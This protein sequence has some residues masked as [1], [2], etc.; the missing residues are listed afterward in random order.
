MSSS[1]RRRWPFDPREWFAGPPDDA[2]G[3]AADLIRRGRHAQALQALDAALL[4]A[5]DPAGVAAV[6]NK[7][8]VALVALGDRDAALE[9]F[10]AALEAHETAVPALVSIGNLL[11][12]AGHAADAVD[13]YR[14]ALRLDDAYAVAHANLAAAL[15]SLGD[16][17][18]AVR[19]L[20]A[21]VRLEGPRGLGRA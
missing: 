21:A 15:R 18:G 12:E 16:R 10:C 3:R 1:R 5:R 4:E 13:Y 20:R 8:G 7:R 11:F 9:A 14:A 17:A 6:H 2:F 19:A